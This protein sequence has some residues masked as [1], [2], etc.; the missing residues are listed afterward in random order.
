M[1]SQWLAILSH[2]WVQL[3]SWAAPRRGGSAKN[4]KHAKDDGW[5]AMIDHDGLLPE[6]SR[7]SRPGTA[8]GEG[9]SRGSA[10]QRSY[11]AHACAAQNGHDQVCSGQLEYVDSYRQLLCAQFH[12]LSPPHIHLCPQLYVPESIATCTSLLVVCPRYM[13]ACVVTHAH[14]WHASSLF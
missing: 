4:I 7:A 1:S 5:T 10:A 12:T 8:R 2:G 3:S 13:Y 14:T 6:R 11:L 9:G